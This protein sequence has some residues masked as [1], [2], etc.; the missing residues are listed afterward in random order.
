MAE[1]LPWAQEMLDIAEATGDSD[2]LIIGH[3]HACGCYFWGGEL[4]KAVEHA[5][6][7]LDLYDAEKHRHLADIV[8]HDPKTR[9]VSSPRVAPGCWATRTAHYG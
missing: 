2:L 9:P 3:T 1:S 7:V 6:K 8:N 5:D 4:I